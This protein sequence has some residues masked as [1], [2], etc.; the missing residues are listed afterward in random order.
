MATVSQ[1]ILPTGK[2]F[3]FVIESVSLPLPFFSLVSRTMLVPI[4]QAK[5]VT[6]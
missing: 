2:F 4:Q 6:F 1:Q 3:A 5:R